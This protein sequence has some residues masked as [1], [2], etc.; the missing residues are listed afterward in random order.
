MEPTLTQNGA[1]YLAHRRNTQR[2]SE[3]FRNFAAAARIRPND[4]RRRNFSPG[5]H[6]FHPDNGR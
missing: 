1:L 5:S 4:V 2:R 6:R 3:A